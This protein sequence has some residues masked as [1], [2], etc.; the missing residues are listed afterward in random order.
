[1]RLIAEV[2]HRQGRPRRFVICA[3]TPG[4]AEAAP[5]LG[6]CRRRQLASTSPCRSLQFAADDCDGRRI[7]ADR[8]MRAGDDHPPRPRRRRGLRDEFATHDNTRPNEAR[9]A[10]ARS[11]ASSVSTARASSTAQRRSVAAQVYPTPDPVTSVRGVDETMRTSSS[12]DQQ[13]G[14]HPVALHWMDMHGRPLLPS[15]Q[16]RFHRARRARAVP[17]IG[18]ARLAAPLL[19]PLSGAGRRCDRRTFV[20]LLVGP[21]RSVHRFVSSR[22]FWPPA[23][24]RSPRR[25]WARK[26]RGDGD[27]DRRRAALLKDTKARRAV[28]AHAFARGCWICRTRSGSDT[29]QART[30]SVCRQRRDRRAVLTIPRSSLCRLFFVECDRF[31]DRPRPARRWPLYSSSRAPLSR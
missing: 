7:R 21:L 16:A 14:A 10:Y 18:G 1:M 30:R 6:S 22:A 25:S 17:C 5:A 11:S 23:A 27:R 28:C 20:A 13:A 2:A 3:P 31:G 12:P 29:S 19:L 4:A 9:T 8:A 15:G 26:T 24:R